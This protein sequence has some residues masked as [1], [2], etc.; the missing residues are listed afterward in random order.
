MATQRLASHP[1]KS[2]TD[3]CGC[4]LIVALNE[5]EWSIAGNGFSC[6]QNVSSTYSLMCEAAH[7]L[8]WPPTPDGFTE[9][10]INNRID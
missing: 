8:S 9:F 7:V 3:L 1:L 10:L 4:E 2:Y 5:A 6:K